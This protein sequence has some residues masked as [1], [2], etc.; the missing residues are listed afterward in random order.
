MHRRSIIKASL[1]LI[2]LLALI[3][4][5]PAASQSSIVVNTLTDDNA[6]NT[7]CSLREAIT[8]A[9]NNAAYQG[10]TAG[11]I[12]GTDVIQF[13]SSLFSSGTMQTISIATALPNLSS[14]LE[15][16]G[17]GANLLTIQRTGSASYSVFEV[18]NGGTATIR[19]LA[20][21]GGSVNANGG[22]IFNQ[23]TLTAD[24]LWVYNNFSNGQGGG[25]RNSGT[26]TL[27]NSTISG[28]TAS[29]NGGGISN[30]GTMQLYNNTVSGNTS[31]STSANAGGGGIESGGNQS[32]I[33]LHNNTITLN[34]A[35]VAGRAGVY[36]PNGT[37]TIANNI[38]AGN[39]VGAS[40]TNNCSFGGTVTNN[41]NNLENGTTCGW[42]STNGNLSSANA[43]LGSLAYNGGTTQTHR[44][45]TGS[46]ALDAGNNTICATVSGVNNQDQRSY[47]RPVNTTCDI[48]SVEYQGGPSV[49]F[50]SAST[51][52]T[53]GDS[54]SQAVTVM[55]QLRIPEGGTLGAITSFTLTPSGTATQTTDYTLSGTSVTF[56]ASSTNGATQSITVNVL[57][58]AL[59]ESSETIALMLSASGGVSVG[60]TGTFTLTINDNDAPASVAFVQN[61]TSTTA[62]ATISPSVTVEI[63]NASGTRITNATNSVSLSISP[64]VSLNGTLT[65]TAASGLATFNDLSVNTA[66]SYT[67]S[68]SSSGLT[69]ATSSLFTISAGTAAA[70]QFVQQPSTTTAGSAI[71]PAVTVRVVDAFGNLVTSGSQT[72]NIGISTGGALS[73]GSTTSVTTVNG[74]ATFV[75]LAPTT[76]GSYTL[77]ASSSGLTG[78]TSGSFTVNAGGASTLQFVQQPTDTTAGTN[79]SPAV[80]V[81]VVDAFGN[82][83]TSG[84]QTVNVAISTGGTLSGGSTTSVTTVN[85]V[86]T[87]SNLVPTTTGLYTLTAS[88]SG[89]TGATS[90]SFT[91]N[92]GAA[93]T[94]QFVQQPT[95]TTAGTNIS[96]AVTV[97]VVDAYGNLV[98]AG[99][100]TVNIGISTGGALSGGSTTSV[101]TVNGVA[102]FNNLAPTA[103]G[104]YTLNASSSGLTGATSNAFTVSPGA[105]ANL[106]FTQQPTNATAGVNLNPAVTVRATDLYGNSIAGISVSLASSAGTLNGT[107]TLTTD[108][109]GVATFSNL[110]LNTAGSYTLTASSGPVSRESDSFTISAAAAATLEFIQEPTNVTAGATINPAVNVR[111]VDAFGNVVTG[112]NSTEVTLA[113]DPTAT[114]NGTT[115]ATVVNGVAT[116]NDLSIN[117]AGSYTL[118]ATGTGL[119]GDTSASFT[120][121]AGAA[122]AL[123]F[124]QEPTN[125]TAGDT[126]NPAVTV[127]V[128]DVFGN[129]VTGDNSTEVT[130]ALDPAATLNGTTAATVV[131]GVATFNDLSINTAGSYTLNAT[132]TGL[133]GDTSASFTVTPHAAV[134]L[135]FGQQ[136]TNVS[137]GATISPAV[138]VRV[139]DTFGNLVTDANGVEVTLALNP[140]ATLNGTTTATLVNGV[141]TFS[142]LSI[143]TAG[144]YTLQATL[145]GLLGATSDSFTVTPGAAAALE[146]VQEPTNVTAGST[147]TPAVTVRVVDA[148]GNLVTSDNSTEVTLALDPTG[149]LNG[150]TT[151]AVVNGVATF[152]DLVPTTAG[153]YT[154]DATS[155]GLTGDTSDSFTVNAGGTVA[156][157]TFT[158]PPTDTAAGTAINPAVKVR[159]TDS[160][161][162]PLAGV[163][164]SLASSISTLNGTITGTTDANGEATFSN[165]SLNTAGMYTLT[166]AVG[167]VSQTSSAFTVHAGAAAVLDFVQEPTDVTAGTAIN[168]AVTVRVLDAFGNLVTSGSQTVDIG[169]S[170]GGTFSSGSTTSVTTVNGVA[171][172]NNLVPTSAG[173][174][175][176][177]AS[178]SGLTG[179]TSS[180]F[181]VNPDALAALS[182]TQQP[183]NTL[184]GATIIPAV[185]VRA[186]DSLGNSLVGVSI[187]LAPSSGTLNGTTT[188]TT[189]SSGAATFN[190]LSLNTAGSY[191]LTATAGS[192][193][194]SS[195][196]FTISAGAPA[197]LVFVDQPD[198]ATAGS[199]LG[200]VVL[201]V[202]DAFGNLVTGD[203]STAVTLTLNTG[204][205]NGTLMATAINGVITFN[206]LS[207]NTAG[208]YTIGAASGSL[209]AT[210]DA[211]TITSGAA[212]AMAFVQQ[213][214][215]VRVD[216][217]ITPAVSVELSDAY[218]NRVTTN[219]TTAV[220]LALSPASA[221]LNGTLTQ[222]VVNGVATFAN[223]SVNTAGSYSL[224]A[225]AGG[226]TPVTSAPFRVAGV[227]ISTTLPQLVVTDPQT[228]VSEGSQVGDRFAIWLGGKPT[229]NVTLTFQVAPESRA[230]LAVINPYAAPN[231]VLTTDPVSVVYNGADDDNT[232]NIFGWNDYYFVNVGAFFND[233]DP[234]TTAPDALDYTELHRINLTFSSADPLYNGI[235][236]TMDVTV[237]EAGVVITPINPT[238]A[239]GSS[240]Q[241]T[242]RLSSPP[243]VNMLNSQMGGPRSERVTVGLG[244]FDTNLL[245]SVTPMPLVFD[246][247]NWNIPRTMTVVPRN[248]STYRGASY[249]A[250]LIHTVNS[251]INLNP[252]A[253]SRYGAVGSNVTAPLVTVTITDSSRSSLTAQAAP[254]SLVAPSGD[255]TTPFPTFVWTPLE[256]ATQ[257]RLHLINVN[258][259][260]FAASYDAGTVCTVN[261][262][263]SINVN[264]ALSNAFY[265]WSLEA[266][267]GDGR[268]VISTENV[269]QV[270]EAVSSPVTELPPLPPPV[271]NAAAQ[272]SSPGEGMIAEEPLS[273]PGEGG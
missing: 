119:T 211:F 72:V 16:S 54:G 187:S 135:A 262:T 27:R 60:T 176:L 256:G 185:A 131:N 193:N 263:C 152:S 177:R 246:R 161:G 62:G 52:V 181:T 51:S 20:I 200:S 64:S 65:R 245:T 154:L 167:S 213:P 56:P 103:A 79:I 157:L 215:G 124:V 257:Y 50:T 220:T 101:T 168:P 73:S 66:G 199:S 243:S 94:L 91:V 228:I 205:L 178:G 270:I 71:S 41:G 2:I 118:S 98:T 214:S 36:V 121:N 217:V 224:V 137:A 109:S 123:E 80:T 55:V 150:T 260:F 32:S 96:P 184:A 250:N 10:C 138:T 69:G 120:V 221:T 21:T 3:P 272:S 35:Q 108:S 140:A 47:T 34:V 209:T 265:K 237:Y 97:R 267:T 111:V 223:L 19:N 81:R 226:F 130:L 116:F 15:I 158:Q 134:G 195:L 219:N 48:G 240:T 129:V 216:A 230:D 23:G 180:P 225:S 269:F 113:L 61:P 175:T 75:N 264:L 255:V 247:S 89:L 273:P 210:S 105:F 203:N 13:S 1:F 37:L 114:L 33:T 191:T 77:T 169:I 11:S 156:A 258:G 106:V 145:I 160:F 251:D 5:L 271:Q 57:G 201:Q 148:F 117:T 139:V 229:A 39:V 14:N 82:L 84:S 242:V 197:Q 142:D 170:A 31:T 8:A 132:G 29:V 30:Q 25:I 59:T 58:D 174:Y 12:A 254:L 151:V 164:I 70:L 153:S 166:A 90:S 22:G 42:G 179:D 252:R 259:E 232:N 227:N 146:F 86:A 112:D 63:R 18:S 43:N 198:N 165:L 206:N 149:T 74:V 253:D 67:L 159:A 234:S 127:R 155:T 38:I 171:T 147:I 189:D 188:A 190:N 125:V 102:T 163:S 4:V 87:F 45:G 236:M 44:P 186:T 40:N 85:G 122:A 68:A 46:A 9:A 212:V 261:S 133:T 208:T 93:S 143:N 110:S 218:G 83:I 244:A 249:T 241:Y 6:V 76:A 126:L 7:L 26:M 115:T 235:S 207:V 53:E 28:N 88:S 239:K 104:L 17:P 49:I 100:R 231:F 162:N 202:R 99:S 233:D 196:P 107:T 141:A 128:V 95:D 136:P 194:Q 173:T 144:T 248:D 92:A 204:T 192:I 182:F 222:T 268:V 172:F 24:G 78:A 183:T 266:V 238:V